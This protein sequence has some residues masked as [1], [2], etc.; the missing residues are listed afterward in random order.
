MMLLYRKG[1][2]KMGVFMVEEYLVK[3]NKQGE[4]KTLMQR[5]LAYKKENPK[6]FKELKSFRL[7]H[8]MFGGLVGA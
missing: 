4:N 8:Q 6:L 5:L 3:P 7:F 2:A 1:D